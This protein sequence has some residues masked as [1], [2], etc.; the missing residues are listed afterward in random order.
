[1]LKLWG[2]KTWR[3]PKRLLGGLQLVGQVERSI[4]SI[5]VNANEASTHHLFVSSGSFAYALSDCHFESDRPRI[6]LCPFARDLS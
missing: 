2:W 1:M 3:A 5:F 4:F 6:Q